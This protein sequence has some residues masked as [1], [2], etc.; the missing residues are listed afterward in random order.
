[1]GKRAYGSNAVFAF[2]KELNYG[3]A[4]TGNYYRMPFNSCDLGSESGLISDPVLG[5]GRDP[6]AP[7]KD[8]TN[9]DGKI[10][11]PV[12]L[13]YFGLWLGQLFGSPT[14]TD[15]TT[16]SVH[17]KH[18]FKSG[19]DDLPSFAGEVGHSKA[20]QYFMNTGVV[21]DSLELAWNRSGLCQATIQLIAQGEVGPNASS[22][23]GT[24][25]TMVYEP[26]NNFQGSIKKGGVAIGNLLSGS[27]K[28]ANNMER[29]ETIRADGKIEGVD[30]S[31]AALTGNITVRFTDDN[32]FA[33]AQAGTP[34]DL[35]F[36]FVK[37]ATQKI[38][39][40]IP[41]VYLPKPK[42]PINGAG[43]VDASFDFQC[44]R[45]ATAGYMLMVTLLN[46]VAAGIY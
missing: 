42:L 8:V 27:L 4:P 39:F 35:E 9:D 6:Y 22:S 16:P 3:V 31:Q 37:S 45:N 13:R 30:P 15:E 10:V 33:Q 34:I 12:D 43:G 26:F 7:Q 36:S 38:V 2:K 18:V 5:Q 25:Q 28:Y 41:E 23:A 24:L 17:K 21:A 20:L 40:T 11:V 14:T 44:S 32:L 46:D 29:V 19:V 1:M